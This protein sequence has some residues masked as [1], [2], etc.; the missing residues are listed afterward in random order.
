MENLKYPELFK[1]FDIGSCHVKNRV[2]MTAMDTKHETENYIW[3]DET[4]GYYI[5]RAKG[6]VGLIHTYACYCDSH[7]EN[8]P[9]VDSPFA[10]P[11]RCRE[12]LTKLADGV[13]KYGCKLFVQLWSGFGRIAFPMAME[14]DL[15]S[16]SDCANLWDP[17]SRCRALTKDEIHRIVK[18][19]IEAAKL[20]QECGADGVNIVA[21]YG[22]YLGDQM[23][24][25]LFNR[26]TDEYGGSL[27]NR[28][29]MDTEII[30][31]IKA[32]CGAD[33]PVTCRFSI[34]NHMKSI[35]HGHMPEEP[36]TEV[37]RDTAESI[38]LAK[39][40]V[41]AGADGFLIGE[42]SYDAMYWQYP[43]MYQKE[44]LWLDDVKPFAREIHVPI[45]CPG[46]ILMPDMA[47]AAIADGTLTAAALGRALLADPQWP[48]KAREGRDEDIRPC[49]GCN[50][51]CMARVMSG[52]PI[53]CAV[54]A[55][56][57]NE[58][59]QAYVPAEVKKKIAV[60]GAGIGGMETARVAKLRGHDVTVFE[61]SDRVGGL[62][63][64]ASVPDFKQGDRRLISWYEK[65]MRDLGIEVRLNT[66]ATAE[67]LKAGRLRCRCR[68]HRHPAPYPQYAGHRKGERRVRRGRAV[69]KGGLWK[70]AGDHRRRLDRL[71]DGAVAVGEQG[72][73]HLRG[74]DEPGH[75]DRRRDTARPLQRA[76]HG[77]GAGLP[78][79]R[80]CLYPRQGRLLRHQAGEDKPEE[81]GR[82]RPS[83]RHGDNLHRPQIPA[84]PVRRAEGELR[85]ERVS[86]GRRGGPGQYPHRRPEGQRGGQI[87]LRTSETI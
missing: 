70:E 2:V 66:E 4:I 84:R 57:F 73:G 1:P 3:S 68:R 21:A 51:G 74:G 47:N 17:E 58:R 75:H 41:A 31:G 87:H 64:A 24:M 14:G 8:G 13:H 37:G 69:R 11:A 16:A 76:V 48:E 22:G 80:A 45:M 81:G 43:P 86:G 6:G 60:V 50:N 32:A 9:A 12:Q 39:L 5:E 25:E 23:C 35:G 85:R 67:T 59:N 42:G 56:L 55:E 15:V 83:R 29:R 79:Q 20:C 38:A 62:F 78:A 63:V 65:Q 36:Y 10:D 72:R 53:M 26:R 27:E 52:L 54:N 34:R 7:V 77:G 19:H 61:K 30:S 44:G 49:I 82:N 40:F 46:R 71:R 33:F 28:A 18:A